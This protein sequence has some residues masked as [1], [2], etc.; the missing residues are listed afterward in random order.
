MGVKEK[1]HEKKGP[2]EARPIVPRD[3]L[4]IE[5]TRKGVAS[6]CPYCHEDIVIGQQIHR[7]VACKARFHFGCLGESRQKGCSTC[8]GTVFAEDIARR[9]AIRV[10]ND[11]WEQRVSLLTAPVVGAAFFAGLPFWFFGVRFLARRLGIEGLTA[12]AVLLLPLVFPVAAAFVTWKLLRRTLAA[13][14]RRDDEPD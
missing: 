5:T 3:D 2:S 7:C 12:V 8:G 4:P 6:R 11:A 13:D 9:L 1:E 14:A 10:K